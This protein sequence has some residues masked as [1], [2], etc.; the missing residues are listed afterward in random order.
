MADYSDLKSRILFGVPL[1]AVCL[2]C[3]AFKTPALVLILVIALIFVYEVTRALLKSSM[4]PDVM[5]MTLSFLVLGA[6]G[7]CS[8]MFVRVQ[9]H[10]FYGVL[11]VALG[12]IATDSFAYLSG[13]QF[14]KTHFSKTSPNKTVEGLLFGLALGMLTIGATL[15]LLYSN[16]RTSLSGAGIAATVVLIPPVAV[17]GDLFESK[18]KR[19]LGIKDFSNLLGGHGGIADRFDAMTAAFVVFAGVTLVVS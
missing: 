2:I 8:A 1:F 14:G 10:G 16:D 18:T 11:L 19:L 6:L 4:N 17:L 15:A 9:E 7:F 3:L 13:R 12:V 5:R